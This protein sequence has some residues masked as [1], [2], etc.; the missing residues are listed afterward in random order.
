MS[1]NSIMN[2]GVTAMLSQQQAL[3]ITSNN[4]ANVQTEGYARKVVDFS[5][6]SINGVASGVEISEIRR[7][8][9]AFIENELRL[10]DANTEQYTAMAD[11]YSKL[12]ALMGDPSANTSLTGKVD[13]IHTSFAALTLDTTLSVSRTAALTELQN[14]GIETDRLLNQVQDL[15]KDAD[16]HIASE[17]N[18]VNDAIIRVYELNLEIVSA[19]ISEQPTGELED[20]RD[21]ALTEISKIMDIKIYDQGDGAIAVATAAGQQLLDFQPRQLVYS[22]AATVTSETTFD[23]ISI[24]V[25]DTVNKTISA[26]GLPL[27]PELTSGSLRGWLD[28]RNIELPALANQIGALAAATAE[29]FNAVHNDNVAVPPPATLVG[30]NTGVIAADDH[31]FTGQATFYTFDANDEI[32]NSYTVDFD[33]AATV[34]M[35]D[36]MTEVNGALGAGTL[37]LTNGA[38]TM[39]APAGSTGVG[40][41]QDATTPADRG[42]KGFSHFFGMNDLVESSVSTNFETGLQAGDAHNF[43]GTSDFTFIGPDGQTQS[44]FTINFGA[45]GGTMADVLTELNTGLNPAATATLSATGEIEITNATGFENYSF[46]VVNDGTDRGATGL[47]FTDMFGLGLRYPSDQGVGFT[48][49]ADILAS[50][51]TMALADVDPTGSPALTLAD[52]RGALS[53]QELTSQTYDFGTVGGL[54]GSKVTLSDYASQVLAKSGLDAA[55]AD[56]LEAD[57]SALANVLNEKS[58]EKSG[59]NMDEEL[60]NLIVYQNSYNAAA[61]IIT[62]ARDMYDVM[63]SIV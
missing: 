58:M 54:P 17:I 46:T 24:N 60:A 40:M 2:T 34:T 59:V 25:Y 28:M 35:T 6:I 11:I 9:D 37:T 8:T 47:A 57:R 14:F 29:Q 62:T 33:N 30:D 16:S 41:A 56:S 63:L 48:V 3:N 53:F 49:R 45:I 7:I 19:S 38:L 39:A 27:D 15:R 44:T 26:T 5:S 51:M 20:Q 55:R 32:V 13:S 4:I 50:P 42:G 31:G 22:A 12:Q 52:N 1:L 10:A 23:Q 21:K 18:T 36:V 61:R 43:T